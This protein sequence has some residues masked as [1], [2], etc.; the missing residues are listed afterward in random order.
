M[1]CILLVINWF[2]LPN[3][4]GLYICIV[5]FRPNLKSIRF[6]KRRICPRCYR[7]FIVSI[8]LYQRF[9]DKNM[10][11]QATSFTSK[12]PIISARL[13]VP[14]SGSFIRTSFKDDLETSAD[15]FLFTASYNKTVS[16]LPSA[17]FLSFMTYL[18]AL[19]QCQE[20]SQAY[21]PWCSLISH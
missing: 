8:S 10:Q 4:Q 17:D 5:A 9:I 15:S 11:L 6:R 21:L 2:H 1:V 13:C 19:I 18:S 16:S 20:W 14:E 12:C 3:L 7:L